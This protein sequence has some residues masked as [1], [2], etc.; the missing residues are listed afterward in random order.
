[1][2]ILVFLIV[3]SVGITKVYSQ[4]AWQLA[5]DKE[6]IKVY[7][8]KVSFSD[9]FAFKAVMSVRASEMEVEKILKDIDNYPKWFAFTASA[10]LIKQTTNEQQFFM[11]IDYPWP[12]SN[13]CMNYTMNFVKIQGNKQE[14]TIIGTNKNTNCEYSL[15]RANGYILLEPDNENTKITY[16]FHSE[17][18]QNIPTWL[19]NPRIHEMPFQTFIS[20]RK[21]LYK[22]NQ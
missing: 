20:L 1:M 19:I 13:E 5:K 3:I 16:Y 2:K 4:K 11:E 15:K 12:Y 8:S 10:K 9:Y 17:P 14:I 6:G 7:V 21:K 22:S 18:S